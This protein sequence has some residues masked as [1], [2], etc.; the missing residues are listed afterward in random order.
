MAR[1]RFDNLEQEKQAEILR[2]AGEEFADNGYAQAS[3]NAIIERAGISKG[4]LYY[5]FENK[6][7]LFETVMDRAIQHFMDLLGGFSLR[8]LDEENFWEY[9]EQ[10]ALQSVELVREHEWYVRLTRTFYRL[11]DEAGGEGPTN[12]LWN[13]MKDWV[14]RV[15]ER[16]QQLGV[17][18]RDLPTA[19]LVEVVMAVGE[20]TDR[21]MLDHIDEMDEEELEEEALRQIDVFRRLCAPEEER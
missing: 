3:L 10:M 5:Y 8:E 6:E 11:R 17:V 12:R 13:W 4:S 16:G 18:R 15:L 21:W 7:D 19:Y 2:E 14:C 20:A 9:F 1:S